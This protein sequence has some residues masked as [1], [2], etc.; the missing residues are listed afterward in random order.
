MDTSFIVH[1]QGD[2]FKVYRN[3]CAHQ[4][5]KFL[6]DLEDVNVA[7]CTRHGW[8]FDGSTGVYTN[9]P[10]NLENPCLKQETLQTFVNAA[11]DL[12]IHESVTERTV[13]NSDDVIFANGR[14][15]L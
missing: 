9:P 3:R 11:G 12:E 6:P 14:F 10:Q 8:K 5:G 15:L 2:D 4:G 13:N 7:S 1:L